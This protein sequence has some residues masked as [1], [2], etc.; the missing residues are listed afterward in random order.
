[1]TKVVISEDVY[2]PA[3]LPHLKNM[4]RTQIFYG[5]SSSGKSVFVA[6]RCVDDLMQGGRN[7]LICRQVAR[8]LRMSVF[9]E[10]I[11]V[12]NEWGV[13][14]LFGNPQFNKSDMIITCA[15][16]YQIAFVGLD[17]VEKIKSI[18]PAKGAWT[19]VWI[20][21]ATETE[22]NTIK[23]LYKRQRGGSEKTP[24]RLT[25]TFNPIMQTHWIYEEYFSL[26]GW[27]DK[28]TRYQASDGS[29]SIFKTTYK[30]NRFLTGDDVRGLESETE[31]LLLQCLYPGKLGDTW[32]R[33]LHQLAGRGF[34]GDARP[35]YQP[36]AWA[37]LWLCR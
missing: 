27:A 19:D 15:N 18:R 29:L 35:V 10:V 23:Q 5:G 6:Q 17:D 16:G 9:S 2:N 33:H 36:Q 31:L 30:D 11:N 34:S 1:M 37:G 25:M 4:A 22:R 21:E 26:L 28:Q 20:E 32:Q 14:V 3:Y 12:I 8:T 13:G 24:K 7:Y